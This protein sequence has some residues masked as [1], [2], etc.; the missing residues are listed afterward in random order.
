MV[1]INSMCLDLFGSC[2]ARLRINRPMRG[3]YSSCKPF[4][5]ENTGIEVVDIFRINPCSEFSVD[6]IA[7]QKL[8][9]D[10][11]IHKVI[12]IK[13]RFLKDTFESSQG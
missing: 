11:Q 6:E 4:R 5:Y 1:K 10:S 9:H 8:L 7:N 13:P 3:K 12:A 2:G